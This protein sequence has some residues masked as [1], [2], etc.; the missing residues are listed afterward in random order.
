MVRSLSALASASASGS[1]TTNIMYFMLAL[2]AGWV[3]ASDDRTTIGG[4]ADPT[5]GPTQPR[6]S[7]RQTL[8]GL[9]W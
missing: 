6:T 3:S 2:L 5:L 9:S 1:T 7:V 8:F 4:P